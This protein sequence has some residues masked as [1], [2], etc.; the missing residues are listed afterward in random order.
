MWINVF[1]MLSHC[2]VKFSFFRFTVC[3]GFVNVI[4]SEIDSPASSG[5]QCKYM[6]YVTF[7]WL[8]IEAALSIFNFSPFV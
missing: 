6:K 3:I 2:S 8:P 7:S 5:G 1:T 4:G